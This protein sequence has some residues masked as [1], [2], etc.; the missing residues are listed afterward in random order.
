MEKARASL[1]PI[2]GDARVPMKEVHALFGGK[3]KPEDVLTAALAGNP[4]QARLD[5]QLFYAH[6]YLGL[7]FEAIGDKKLAGEHIFQAAELSKE[8]DYMGDVARVHAQLLR[9]SKRINHNHY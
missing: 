1:I 3:A 5:H 4:P 2:E 8:N 9:G 6:L 7:Y